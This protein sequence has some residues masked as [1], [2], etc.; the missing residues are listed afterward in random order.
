MAV[1]LGIS[2]QAVSQLENEDNISEERLKQIADALGVTPEI[3]RG[4]DEERIFFYINSVEA[5]SVGVVN[6]DY[7]NNVNPIEKLIEI[8]E[9]LLESEREKIEILKN[10]K[11]APIGPKIRK[12]RIL[13]D[14]SQDDLALKMKMSKSAVS[15][16]ENS[17]QI[18]EDILKQ[19]CEILEVSVEGL[20]KF[21]EESA[22]Y[23]TANYFDGCTIN[24]NGGNTGNAPFG[25]FNYNSLE[26][27]SKFFEEQLHKAK[28]EF[29]EELEK[30]K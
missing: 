7:Y 20:K 2:Q 5:N 18:E 13:R 22:L 17:F 25:T 14:M 1:T 19:V 16:L 29:K 11:T 27:I 28:K 8:Y 9:R 3:I 12:A 26:E 15:R 10:S 4:F 6:G 30:K 24:A 21:D 23:Y